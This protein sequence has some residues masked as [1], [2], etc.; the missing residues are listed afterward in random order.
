MPAAPPV[1]QS[2]RW[3]DDLRWFAIAWAAGFLFFLL[4]LG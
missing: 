3:R 2:A 1:S 4:L